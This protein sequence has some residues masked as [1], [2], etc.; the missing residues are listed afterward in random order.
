VLFITGVGVAW[1]SNEI[2]RE[3]L[4]KSFM[5][6]AGW[7]A[8]PFILETSAA[9]TGVIVVLTYNEWRRSK[10]GPEWVEMEV[11]DEADTMQSTNEKQGDPRS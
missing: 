5:T 6:L 10:E 3:L 9:I 7:L 1:K 2:A 8:T 4:A 11:K